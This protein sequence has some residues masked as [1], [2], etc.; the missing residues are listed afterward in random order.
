MDQ[1]IQWH[2]AFCSAVELTLMKDANILHYTRELNLTQ[3]PLQADLFVLYLDDHKPIDNGISRYFK[4]YNLFEYKSPGVAL[5]IDHYYK[6]VGYC[7]Q[8]KAVNSDSVNSVKAEDITMILV[9]HSRPIGIFKDLALEG[10]QAEKCYPGI[11]R[12]SG[13]VLFTTLVI[14][15]KELPKKDSIWL[16]S[17]VRKLDEDQA[18]QLLKAI[19]QLPQ[20]S[21]EQRLAD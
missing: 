8:F 16:T 17:L 9:R 6:T 18:R 5:T 3:K 10:I 2:P 1:K 4:K 7:C 14:V 21:K 11:Y 12:L 19:D 15:T 20:R 13:R